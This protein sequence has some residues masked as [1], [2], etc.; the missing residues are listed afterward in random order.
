MYKTAASSWLQI[1]LRGWKKTPNTANLAKT[2]RKQEVVEEVTLN[3][4]IV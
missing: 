1:I 2:T 3:L 4:Q